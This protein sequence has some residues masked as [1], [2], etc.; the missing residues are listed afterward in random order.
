MSPLL[1]DGRQLAAQDRS[2]PATERA[3]TAFVAV[4]RAAVD[5]P[6]PGHIYAPQRKA[7]ED[8][9]GRGARGVRR[10]EPPPPQPE[11]FQLFEEEPGGGGPAPLSEVAGWQERIQRHTVEHADAIC[12]FVQ[13][14]DAPVPQMVD[15]L[16]VVLSHV[17]S[18]VPE[19]V[20]VVP[21][22]SWPSHFPRTVLQEPQKVEQLVEA[23]TIVSLIEV[24]RLPVVQT[25]DFPVG[26]GG[27]GSGG[28]QGFSPGRTSLQCTGEQSVHIL[29]P[30]GGRHDLHPPSAADFSNPPD[31]A[32]Q[33]FFF[34]TFPRY[35]KSAKI[36]RA[37][38]CESAPGLEL[39]AWR[40]GV[41][42]GVVQ[43]LSQVWTE[44]VHTR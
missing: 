22:I 7:S 33:G 37:Q 1:R 43:K 18:F 9:Q 19:Q 25:V 40:L 8:G 13:I 24:I 41:L 32:D 34:R 26:A 28:L 35:K 36:P 16:V 21:K 39:M 38:W 17:D 20:S 44:H 15:Q 23:P 31:T 29:V 10:Q 6:G 30:H 42:H 11:L 4:A 5:R 14:L 3:T 27:I 12:P 2:C